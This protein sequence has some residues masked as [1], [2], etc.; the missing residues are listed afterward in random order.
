VLVALT[1]RRG[2]MPAGSLTSCF[3]LAALYKDAVMAPR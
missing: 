3:Q 1:Q 2:G